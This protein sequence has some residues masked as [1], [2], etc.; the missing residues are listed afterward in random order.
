MGKTELI[1]FK[2]AQLVNYLLTNQYFK[3]LK[4]AR[5]R[6]IAIYKDRSTSENEFLQELVDIT[7]LRPLNESKAVDVYANEKFE[8]E[9]L[10][11][12]LNWYIQHTYDEYSQTRKDL[13]IQEE[14][15]LKKLIS[16]FNLNKNLNPQIDERI[17][18]KYT[19]TKESA[20]DSFNNPIHTI[21]FNETVDNLA[22]KGYFKIVDFKFDLFA[23]P[24]PVSKEKYDLANSFEELEFYP[25][26]HCIYKLEYLDKF[27]DLAQNNDEIVIAISSQTGE[28]ITSKGVKTTFDLKSN[29][30]KALLHF[31]NSSKSV[32]LKDI[33]GKDYDSYLSNDIAKLLRKKLKLASNHIK[34]K[35]GALILTGCRVEIHS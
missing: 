10:V 33:L 27:L 20:W 3:D 9:I 26:Q 17:L 29:E 30:L 21:K 1:I 14:E 7:A 24:T 34:T 35:A 23:E 6:L 22:I 12:L 15:L 25:P 8:A 11:E 28:A 31:K 2:S 4:G 16:D 19:S 32:S 5:I 13:S 18:G